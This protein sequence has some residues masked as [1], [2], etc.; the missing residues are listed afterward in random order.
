MTAYVLLWGIVTRTLHRLLLSA[1]LITNNIEVES[2]WGHS[3]MLIETGT[4]LITC[5]L[6][7]ILQSLNELVESM[8][9]NTAVVSEHAN[10]ERNI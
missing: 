9:A 6:R 10:E 7:H 5:N 4:H 8:N 1:F 2:N 3:V